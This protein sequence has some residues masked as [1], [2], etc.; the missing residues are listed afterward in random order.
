MEQ[1]CCNGDTHK[2]KISSEVKRNCQKYD[3]HVWHRGVFIITYMLLW[4]LFV[5]ELIV[6]LKQITLLINPI[7]AV[8]NVPDSSLNKLYSTNTKPKVVDFF[9]L[10]GERSLKYPWEVKPGEGVFGHSFW[11]SYIFVSQGHP[12][13]PSSRRVFWS[14][15][16]FHPCR[17]VSCVNC[18]YSCVQFRKSNVRPRVH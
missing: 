3:M 1:S 11:S 10:T 12:S 14:R 15:L 18:A 8:Y 16:Q 2:P 6:F 17:E 5:L 7:N 13:S 9:F 4:G